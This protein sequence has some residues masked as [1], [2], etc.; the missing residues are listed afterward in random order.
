VESLILH[1]DADQS[2]NWKAHP[3]AR[4]GIPYDAAT[5][6]PFVKETNHGQRR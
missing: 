1:D 6:T 5:V 3:E 4:V 2:N